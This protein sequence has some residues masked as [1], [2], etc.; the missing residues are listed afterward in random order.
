LLSKKFK[1]KVFTGQSASLIEKL[2]FI[3]SAAAAA[4]CAARAE[5][6]ALPHALG[7]PHKLGSW[8][9]DGV[10]AS[11]NPTARY[12]FARHINSLSPCPLEDYATRCNER[13]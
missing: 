8:S 4:A 1:N 9:H 12:H 13:C 3:A 5:A 6:G 10:L 7:K 2:C 11:G